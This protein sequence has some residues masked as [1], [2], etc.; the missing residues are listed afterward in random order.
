MPLSAQLLSMSG[1]DSK[2][3]LTMAQA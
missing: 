1:A 2:L 3:G